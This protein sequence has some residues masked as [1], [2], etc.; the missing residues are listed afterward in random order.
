MSNY[1]SVN[2]NGWTFAFWFYLG[3]SSLSWPRAAVIGPHTTLYS[4][5]YPGDSSQW[6][7]IYETGSVSG[8]PTLEM[9]F[10]P[11]QLGF[12]LSGSGVD[13]WTLGVCSAQ[14][15]SYEDD[16]T[17]NALSGSACMV[18]GT[19]NFVTSAFVAGDSS[20]ALNGGLGAGSVTSYINTLA[21]N[22]GGD[23]YDYP[24]GPSGSLIADMA[25]WDRGLSL[26]EIT[27]TLWN[28]GKPLCLTD[29]I[30]SGNLKHWL[31]MGDGTND[32]AGNNGKIYDM[33]G[34]VTGT[35]V[36][37][38]TSKYDSVNIPSG[39]SIYVTCSS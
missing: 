7:L 19:D 13:T 39:D 15:Y 33:T 35:I 26:A 1:V 27:G 18:S 25:V 28:G 30:L 34:S 29:S 4:R 37:G 24:Y 9:N 6:M 36:T 8:E 2:P 14:P 22:S 16:G 38:D 5:G 10:A 3:S 23:L 21:K 17:I 12:T 31:R 20:H 11:A 32:T